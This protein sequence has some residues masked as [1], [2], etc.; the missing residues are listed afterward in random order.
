ML[1][2][3]AIV[4]RYGS[5][6]GMVR[7]GLSHV[8]AALLPQADLSMVERLVYVCRGNIC[9]SAYADAVT[10]RLGFE[11]ASFGLRTATG[12]PAHDPVIAEAER[13]GI[14]LTS[15][16]ALAVEDFVPA[17]GDL[18][19]LM[20]VRQ[21]AELRRLPGFA[22]ASLDLLGR[23]GGRP[24]LHDPY[25]LGPSFTATSLRDIERSVHALVER[26]R[27]RRR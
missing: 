22:D 16:Q 20:E 18:Y 11:T 19:L 13:R 15:H 5:F 12:R 17:T 7:L 4:S 27:E 3:P 26:I 6:R 2:T 14:E 21:I 10:R 1:D 8:Q 9:R 23:F 25:G 24:H